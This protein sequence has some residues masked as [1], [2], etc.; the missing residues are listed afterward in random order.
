MPDIEWYKDDQLLEE[1]EALKFEN[2]G[3][4][5]CLVIKN[6]ALTDEAEYKILARNPLGT[7]SCTAD[8]L[9]EESGTKPELIEPMTDVQVICQVIFLRFLFWL[10]SEVYP[11]YVKLEDVNMISLSPGGMECVVMFSNMSL[12]LSQS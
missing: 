5:F 12:D 11:V 2:K 3:D 7:A 10:L 6:A 1:S 4:S 9:V 8:L